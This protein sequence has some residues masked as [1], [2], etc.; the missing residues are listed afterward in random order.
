M[1]GEP[2]FVSIDDM[3]GA[4]WN[5][6]PRPGSAL[7]GVLFRRL[8]DRFATGPLLHFGQ[9]KWYPG[10]SSCRAGPGITGARRRCRSGAIR[11]AHRRC[12]NQADWRRAGIAQRFALA[13]AQRSADRSELSVQAFEDTWYYLWRERRLPSNVTV[14]VS[15]VKDPGTRRLARIFEQGWRR[16]RHV[17]PIQR[18]HNGRRPLAQRPVVPGA[19]SAAT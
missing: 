10:E 6:W 3:D 11:R 5:T 17:L 16:R 8:A 15:K 12:A 2:T 9:G 4:E 7:A 13:F 1:G 18:D 19:R 14:D